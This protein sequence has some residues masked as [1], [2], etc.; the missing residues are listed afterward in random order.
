MAR[1][2]VD[3][4]GTSLVSDTSSKS[5]NATKTAAQIAAEAKATTV[6]NAAVA[7]PTVNN[8]NAFIESLK[9]KLADTNVAAGLNADGTKITATQT[10]M[11]TRATAASDRAALEASDP[12]Y[13][14][15]AGAPS[16]PAGF[17]YTWIGGTT[18]GQYKLYPDIGSSGG[19]SSGAGA[20]GA[21]GASSGSGNANTGTLGVPTTNIDVLKAMLKAQGFTSTVIDSSA[22]YL[23]SLLID[24]LDYDNAVQV[25]LNTKDYTLKNGTKLSSPFYDQYGYLNE[26][27][28]KPKTPSELFNAVEGYKELKTKYGFSDKYLSTESL[29]N[30]VKNNVSVSELDERANAARLAAINA[31]P[32]KTD[33]LM[34]LGYIAT[35]ADLQDFYMDAKIGKEQLDLNRNT[36]AFVAE[37]VRRASSG[38]LVDNAQLST[39]KQLSAA[40]TDK[41]YNEAQIAQLASTGFQNIAET[42]NP[43]TALS[44][45]YE[46]TP[47]TA[48]TQSTIQSE[49]QNE[50]F[51]NMASERRKRLTEQN[52]QA[53]SGDA[54]VYTRLGQTGSLGN[55]NTSGQL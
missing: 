25:F 1:A 2:T 8:I 27:L 18:T 13:N 53:F 49:L 41:G 33:A 26:G 9:T 24:G 29:K 42:L 15:A 43:L 7:N 45:I 40:M 52:K 6:A 4:F 14:K 39:Y 5:P 54:G 47:G 16:A 22:T 19:S 48:A 23:N 30:Y 44:G 10:L 51:K 50:E 55:S 21:S 35:S 46:K 34:K 20:S 12:T 36:G 38:L 17:H 28:T 32:A 3:E 31:D 37:A 11:A